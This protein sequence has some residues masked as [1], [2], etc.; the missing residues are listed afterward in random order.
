MSTIDT[1]YGSNALSSTTASAFSNTCRENNPTSHNILII[2]QP[3]AMDHLTVSRPW[4]FMENHDVHL[5]PYGEYQEPRTPAIPDTRTTQSVGT[6]EMTAYTTSSHVSANTKILKL[7]GTL[8][9]QAVPNRRVLQMVSIANG[10]LG[11][12][13]EPWEPDDV[14]QLG[15]FPAPVISLTFA[16]SIRHVRLSYRHLREFS[17]STSSADTEDMT[18]ALVWTIPAV[19]FNNPSLFFGSSGLAPSAKGWYAVPCHAADLS[20]DDL[21]AD[22]VLCKYRLSHRLHHEDNV[23]DLSIPNCFQYLAGEDRQYHLRRTD[24]G[25]FGGHDTQPSGTATISAWCESHMSALRSRHLGS[26]Q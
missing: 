1:T 19:K 7:V 26:H 3:T 11:K 21:E 6:P 8:P 5:V 23:T 16:F 25:P 9:R 10:D 2:M 17:G 22:N 15:K 24:Y 20:D 14:V 18:S 12:P 4:H 13:W